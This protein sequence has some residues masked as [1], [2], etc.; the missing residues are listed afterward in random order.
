MMARTVKQ[1]S[2]FTR[3]QIEEDSRD[4]D[5]SFFKTGLEEVEAIGDGVGE[6]FKVEPEVEC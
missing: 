3:V 4:D 5:D 1:I 2:A 6:S